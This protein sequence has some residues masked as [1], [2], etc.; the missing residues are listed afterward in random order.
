MP[1]RS[2]GITGA[3]E[4]TCGDHSNRP[5]KTGFE[6]FA[7]FPGRSRGSGDA[8]VLG[9]VWRHPKCPYQADDRI[10]RSANS[11]SVS[12]TTRHR[13]HPRHPGR[14]DR[15][16]PAHEPDPGGDCAGALQVLVRGLRPRPRQA[17][18]KQHVRRN[19]AA[20][21]GK[22]ISNGS[23]SAADWPVERARAYLHAMD[24]RIVDLF[25]DRLVGSELGQIPDGWD[26]AGF[27]DVVTQLRENE[28]PL[29]SPETVYSHYSIPA[30]D[31]GQTPK[32]ELG[33]NIKSVKTRVP[34][35]TVLLSKLNP[36]IERV[37]LPDTTAEDRAICS[38]EF[39]VLQPMPPFHQAY[40]YCLTRSASFRERLQSLVTGTSKSHQRAPVRS[41]LS[42]ES[43]YPHSRTSSFRHGC[44]RI[45]EPHPGLPAR[46]CDASQRT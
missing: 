39:L 9:R 16:E 32:R 18:L 14:Q 5:S 12:R 29:R 26:V 33:A 21:T 40:V 19:H 44:F 37:W 45:N 11:S 17:A 13:P 38:T 43:L 6:V 25:P 15:T 28:N 23:I 31:Q 34:P 3:C 2:C 20:P 30:Y 22:P 46:R 10:V 1:G 24:P 7:L 27:S 42:L 4:S 8:L 35:G 41:I 36:E